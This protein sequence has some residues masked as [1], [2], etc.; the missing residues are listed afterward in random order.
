MKPTI[1]RV[2]NRSA[3]QRILSSTAEPPEVAWRRPPPGLVG[4]AA[5][6]VLAWLEQILGEC[7]LIA[8]AHVARRACRAHGTLV[9]PQHAVAEAHHHAAVVGDEEHGAFAPEIR[10]KAHALLLE[11]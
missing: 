9:Q 2:S 7:H 6:G 8:P 1:G 11:S 5:I 4:S 10:Q 3:R